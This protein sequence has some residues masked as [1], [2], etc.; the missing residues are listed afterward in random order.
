M[1]SIDWPLIGTQVGLGVLLGF[2][3]GY[4]FKK[5]VK[6]AFLVGGIL[7]FV[8]FALQNSGIISIEWNR[9][10]ALYNETFNPPEGFSAAFRSWVDTLAAMIPGVTGFTFGFFW[11]MAKG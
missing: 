6:L 11:G 2:A 5:A 4:T 1:E 10:H 7:L 3:A 8:L 9:I